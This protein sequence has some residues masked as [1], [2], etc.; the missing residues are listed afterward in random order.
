MQEINLFYIFICSCHAIKAQI[1]MKMSCR[2]ALF[3]LLAIVYTG[4]AGAGSTVMGQVRDSAG[5]T[6]CISFYKSGEYSKASDCLNMLLPLMSNAADSIT[7]LKYLGFSYGML[8]MIERAKEAFRMV[9]SMSPGLQIDTLECPPNI[10]LILNQVKLEHTLATIDTVKASGQPVMEQ[11]K[12]PALAL[13]LLGAAVVSA[14]AGGYLYYS[15]NTFRQKYRSVAT[16][17]QAM[18]DDYY[19]KYRNSYIASAACLGVSAVLLP[20]S[21]YLLLRKGHPASRKLALSGQGGG[22]VLTFFF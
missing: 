20:V 4:I 14:G 9:F 16:P 17:D 10:S 21:T 19:L 22:A 18:L 5:P 13:V 3:S 1:T 12:S 7:V 11:R 6:T 15:G 2:T 8:G